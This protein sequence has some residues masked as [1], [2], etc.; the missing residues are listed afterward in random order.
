MKLSEALAAAKKAVDQDCGAYTE[1]MSHKESCHDRLIRT[2]FDLIS[3][4]EEYLEAQKKEAQRIV[5]LADL[6][7]WD[8]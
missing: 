7:R 6:Q 8:G 5:G 3:A 1:C 4:V 2:T